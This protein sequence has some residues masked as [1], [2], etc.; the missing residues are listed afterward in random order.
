MDVKEKINLSKEEALKRLSQEVVPSYMRIKNESLVGKVLDNYI[1]VYRGIPFHSNPFLPV[2]KASFQKINN[3]I[4][5][6]GTWKYHWLTKIFL[7]VF[8]GIM[9]YQIFSNSFK[10]LSF[11]TIIYIL[12]IFVLTI[13][14]KNAKNKSFED[15]HW[16]INNIRII[17]LKHKKQPKGP[18]T[19]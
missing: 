17:L 8:V 7:S 9:F 3:E 19:K 15:K 6:V 4:F 10:I 5:L 11:G 1:Y 16:I 13:I 18:L 12:M 14:W 2:L